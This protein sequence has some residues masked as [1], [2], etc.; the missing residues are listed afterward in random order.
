MNDGTT[1][2]MKVV[3]SVVELSGKEVTCNT[4]KLFLAKS[5][6]KIIKNNGLDVFD[7]YGSLEK[8]FTPV[9][10]LEKVLHILIAEDILAEK[11]EKL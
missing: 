7:Y 4:I 10:F 6:Q 5:S 3:E 8:R 1:D 2:A 11:A 9:V